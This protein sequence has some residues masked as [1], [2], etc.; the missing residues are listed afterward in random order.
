MIS[1]GIR[2]TPSTIY[3]A[4]INYKDNNFDISFEQLQVPKS[5]HEP[6]KLRFI[7]TNIQSIIMAHSVSHVGIRTAEPIADPNISRIKI[8]AVIEELISNTFV[9]NYYSG[10]IKSLS[11]LFGVDSKL[12]K[13]GFKNQNLSCIGLPD[14]SLIPSQNQAEAL[15][16]AYAVIIN[17]KD[18]VNVN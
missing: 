7:R 15:S 14:S 12:L 8:E 4:I 6:N 5:L 18:K 10:A 3:Y 2:V 17:G 16:A 11:S 13:A 9:H 1:M